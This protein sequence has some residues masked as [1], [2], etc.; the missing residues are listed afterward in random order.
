MVAHARSILVL[1]AVIMAGG[2]MTA[3]SYRQTE[4]KNAKGPVITG[5]LMLKMAAAEEAAIRK[6]IDQFTKAYNKGDVEGVL[7]AWTDDAEFVSE[8]GKAYRG[9]DAVRVLLT[10]SITANKGA[11]QSVR[12]ESVRFL[13]PDVAMENGSV[14][15][16]LPDGAE[17]SGKYEA[18]WVKVDGNWLINRVR[19]L[20]EASEDEKPAAV[21]Q[22]KPL[23]WMVGD[24]TD[25]D[26]RGDVT[27]S[28][29]WG[30]GQT[31][32][33]ME[34]LVK[35]ADGKQ[36]TISSRVGYDAANNTLRSWVF[37][38]MGGFGGGVWTR[39][40]NSWNSTSSGTHPD[41]RG[42]GSQDT[43]QYV[44]ENEFTWS[45]KNREVD[46]V[47]MPDLRITFV[48]KNSR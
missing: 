11:K 15:L 44:N 19:D 40:G 29:K 21:T 32:L 26:G 25:K 8:S 31:F 35:Q 6:V 38:S 30:P 46:Q 39:E 41:G 48:K 45:A 3:Q 16:T 4:E 34:F 28:C 13:R 1:V 47:P 43:W 10:K 18:V 9:K 22:L 12:V 37:D 24:W 14:T 17:E 2:L 33:L 20:V 7:A 27:L 23:G 42:A 5:Q 36:L